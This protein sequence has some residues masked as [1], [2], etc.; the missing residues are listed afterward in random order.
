MFYAVVMRDEPSARRIIIPE[1]A[2]AGVMQPV[3]AQQ[4]P[5]APALDISRQGSLPQAQP[6]PTFERG[7][8]V[9]A[10]LQRLVSAAQPAASRAPLAAT[11]PL[12]VSSVNLGPATS[13]FGQTGNAYKVVYVVD[14]SASLMI[15]TAQIIEEMQTSIESLTPMQKFHIVLARPKRVEELQFKRLVPAVPRYTQAARELI[16]SIDRIPDVGAADPMKAMQ[17][18]FAVQPELIYFLTDGDYMSIEKP[19]EQ[20]IDKLNAGR[21]VKIT[22][23]AFSPT[24]RA[25]ALLQ[26]I[27]GRTGGHFRVVEP[28]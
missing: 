22:V 20:T 2:L 19:L 16:H 9:E 5:Q 10:A 7:A 26:R 3:A 11:G 12:L 27:A 21:S 8:G 24:P 28:R 1:A 15:Y 18:A 14:V 6:Q 25:S 17:R 23:I 13:F 4:L